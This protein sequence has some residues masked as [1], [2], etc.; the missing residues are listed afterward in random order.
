MFCFHPAGQRGNLVLREDKKQ[1]NTNR[2]KKEKL[3]VFFAFVS[4]CTKTALTSDID[5]DRLWLVPMTSAGVDA[6]VALFNWSNKQVGPNLMFMSIIF[7]THLTWG[8]HIVL[9]AVHP[10]L[11]TL[12]KKKK[13]AYLF[14]RGGTW[15]RD[16]TSCFAIFLPNWVW[17]DIRSYL[18][19]KQ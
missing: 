11:Q 17:G 7:D 19:A 2:A 6:T 3:N 5:V 15:Q 12:K 16:G 13:S 18:A 14:G 4:K 8:H 9:L 1:I 10:P